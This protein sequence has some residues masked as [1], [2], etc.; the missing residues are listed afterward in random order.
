MTDLY[1]LLKKVCPITEV[2]RLPRP[3]PVTQQTALLQGLIWPAIFQNLKDYD[4]EGLYGQWQKYLCEQTKVK[5]PITRLRRFRPRPTSLQE[6]LV[7]PFDGSPYV[8]SV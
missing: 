5:R 6:M 1:E 2:V 8:R 3:E 7:H 4:R